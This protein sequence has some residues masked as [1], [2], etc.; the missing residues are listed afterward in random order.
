MRSVQKR[1]QP[2]LLGSQARLS[3]NNAYTKFSKGEFLMS[4]KFLQ[5]N[6]T[7]GGSRAEFVQAFEPYAQTLADTPGL[8]WKIWLLNEA[9]HQAGGV[10]LFNDDVSLKAY[11]EGPI[12]ATVK[13]LPDVS[14]KVFDIAEKQSLMT[15]APIG[16]LVKT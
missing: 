14:V 2:I 5:V 16:E 8:I 9:D 6:F 3:Q 15:R 12:V 13:T 4:Q 10:Y 11:L 1:T 7:F